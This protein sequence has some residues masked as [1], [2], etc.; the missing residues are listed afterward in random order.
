MKVAFRTLGCKVNQYETAAL[1]QIFIDANYDIVDFEINSD[2]YVINTCTVT[3]LGQRKSR[4]MIRRAINTNPDAIIVVTGCYAQTAPE[5][6][7]GIFGVDLVIGTQE[8]HNILPLINKILIERQPI[9]AVSDISKQS[10]FEDISAPFFGERTRATLKIQEGCTEFCSYCIIPYARGGIRSRNISSIIEQAELIV[11]NGYKEIVLAGIHLGA[12]G[13][14]LENITLVDVLH[15]LEQVNGLERIRISSIEATEVDDELLVLMKNSDKFCRHLHLP[16]QAA[17]NEILQKMN[18][19][20]SV[21]EYE[22]IINKIRDYIPDIAITTDIIVGFPGETEELF[23]QG[24]DFLN[25]ISFADMHIFKYSK[26]SGT[27]AAQMDNQVINTDKE[28]RSQVLMQ[29][30]KNKKCEYNNKFLNKSLPVIVEQSWQKDSNLYEGHSDN[31]IKIIFEANNDEIGK[32]IDV[33]VTDIGAD[34]CFGRKV[35]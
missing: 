31:Y 1:E 19:K 18:R 10:S 23:D 24:Y 17:T 32:L 6:I 30:N 27:P 11:K 35:E 25:K 16:I 15:K 20:Y 21:E 4:Q 12:Y 2:I 3:N 7:L 14:D 34:H 22:Q 33:K 28:K 5:E 9:N 29:L 26:R 13:R 8:R